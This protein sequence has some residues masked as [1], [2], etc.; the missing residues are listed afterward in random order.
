MSRRYCL[1]AEMDKP[2]LKVSAFFSLAL[3]FHILA[4]VSSAQTD[5]AKQRLHGIELYNE[6]KYNEAAGL[7]KKAVKSNKADADA[8]YYLGLSL[9]QNPKAL[10]DASKAFETATKLRPNSA[11]MHIAFAYA[12]LRRNKTDDAGREARAALHIQPSGEAYYLLGAYFLR[13]GARDEAVRNAE[14]AIR[15]QP[16]YGPA[17]LLKSQALASFFGDVLISES[18]ASS[19]DRKARFSQAASALE[20]YLELSPNADN[21]QTWNE[22]LESLR[23]YINAP[24]PGEKKLVF[25]GKEVTT[26]ARVLSKPEPSYTEAARASDVT[27]TVIMRAIFTAKG[28][29]KHLLIIQSLPLGLTEQAIKAA[30]RIKFIP[31]TKDG[32]PVSTY[33]QLEYNFNLF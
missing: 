19:E 9:L 22:Q 27:G 10:K 7:L 17:Y 28:E 4:I 15:L 1:V 13:T 21:R 8:W 14:M 6:K 20:K 24:K 3:C 18:Q 16:L 32:Q 23:F 11:D 26:K 33:I 25:T 5:T 30:R 2:H 12:L 31:A 29:V